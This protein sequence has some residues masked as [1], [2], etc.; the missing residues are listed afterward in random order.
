[1]ISHRITNERQVWRAVIDLSTLTRALISV[2]HVGRNLKTAF[3]SVESKQEE[4]DTMVETSNSIL[5]ASS[6]LAHLISA[7]YQCT[8]LPTHGY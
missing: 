3:K 4:H 8:H 6:N 5:E 7:H 1:M 2:V